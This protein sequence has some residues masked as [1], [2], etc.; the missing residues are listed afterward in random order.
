MAPKRLKTP[1]DQI[2]G[3]EKKSRPVSM[4]GT[5]SHLSELWEL[6]V[7]TCCKC[8]LVSPFGAPSGSNEKVLWLEGNA[9]FRCLGPGDR[10]QHN[11]AAGANLSLPMLT[12][13]SSHSFSF[14]PGM[15][16]KMERSKSCSRLL[17]PPEK[18]ST[19]YA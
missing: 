14:V 13:R 6:A 8:P 12:F 15:P 4:Y 7:C 5:R 17:T 2:K 19:S 1:K 10:A 16:Y 9:G 3:K 11:V 18:F